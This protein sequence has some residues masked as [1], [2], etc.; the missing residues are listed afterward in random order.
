[1]YIRDV[2]VALQD[3]GL[4]FRIRISDANLEEETVE[5]RLGEG[6]GAFELDRILRGED[7]EVMAE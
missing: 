7:R 4:F 6:I 5:L 3:G 1:M 2:F